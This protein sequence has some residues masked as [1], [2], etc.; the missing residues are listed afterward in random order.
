MSENDDYQRACGRRETPLQGT[1]F[2]GSL[3]TLTAATFDQQVASKLQPFYGSV[4][5]PTMK[6]LVDAHLTY[7]QVK[8]IREIPPAI[9][10]KIT[11]KQFEERTAA[12]LESIAKTRPSLIRR[13]AVLANRP[14]SETAFGSG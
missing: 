2:F 6:Q 7:D 9:G 5:L 1:D 11:A 10:A 4:F 3:P 13:Q 12:Y 8:N 14:L